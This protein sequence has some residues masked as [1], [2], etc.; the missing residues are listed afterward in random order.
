MKKNFIITESE[1][2]QI[3]KMYGLIKEGREQIQEVEIYSTEYIN[4]DGCDGIA[5]DINNL[6]AAVSRGEVNLSPAGKA[7]LEENKGKVGM[8][9]NITCGM[10]KNKMKE[11]LNQNINDESQYSDMIA[12]ACWM[13][14][15]SVRYT[16]NLSICTAQPIS[17][18]PKEKQDISLS[19]KIEQPSNVTAP[20]PP[21]QSPSSGRFSVFNTGSSQPSGNRRFNF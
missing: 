5:T 11:S 10:A 16:K 19:D 7:S 8:I 13:S 12:T 15:N 3:R 17:N 1:R 18:D 4:K 20:P 21:S 2:D 9:N 6:S 14:K